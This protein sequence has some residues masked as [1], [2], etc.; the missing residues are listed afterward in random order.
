M[1]LLHQIHSPILGDSLWV[2]LTY[3]RHSK[4]DE[5]ILQLFVTLSTCKLIQSRMLMMAA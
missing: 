2:C 5:V 1:S 3:D 4:L